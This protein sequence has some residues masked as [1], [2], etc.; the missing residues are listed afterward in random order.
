MWYCVAWVAPEKGFAVLTAT[1]VAGKPAQK[2]TDSAAWALIQ[3]HL[4]RR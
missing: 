4:R 1:N 3:K 2:A